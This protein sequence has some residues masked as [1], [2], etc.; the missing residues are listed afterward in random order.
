MMNENNK[1]KAET[2]MLKLRNNELE[3]EIEKLR[4]HLKKQ[5]GKQ[6]IKDIVDFNNN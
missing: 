2:N 4:A 5:E 3:S 1:L 6:Y